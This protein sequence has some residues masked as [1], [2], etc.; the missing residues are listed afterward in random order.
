MTQFNDNNPHLGK[1]IRESMWSVVKGCFE[2]NEARLSHMAMLL[3][4]KPKHYQYS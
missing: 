4:A 2:R 1:M 3:W